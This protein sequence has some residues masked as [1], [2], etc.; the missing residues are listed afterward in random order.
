[1]SLSLVTIPKGLDSVPWILGYSLGYTLGNAMIMEMLHTPDGWSMACGPCCHHLHITSLH[2]RLD[3]L[4]LLPFQQVLHDCV[5]DASPSSAPFKHHTRLL[6]A[7]EE[8]LEWLLLCWVRCNTHSRDVVRSL[9]KDSKAPEMLESLFSYSES[10]SWMMACRT[11]EG[12]EGN[13]M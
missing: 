5:M 9:I 6:M 1:V 12:H 13:K 3:I 10:S 7:K 11:F 8:Y 2:P 4:L